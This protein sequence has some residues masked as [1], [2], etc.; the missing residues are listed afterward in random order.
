MKPGL[1]WQLTNIRV[2]V[3]RIQQIV[4]TFRTRRDRRDLVIGPAA[5]RFNQ[6]RL[7][8]AEQCLIEAQHREQTIIENYLHGGQL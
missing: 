8:E 5:R 3:N 4:D 1:N 6:K 2:A 7:W